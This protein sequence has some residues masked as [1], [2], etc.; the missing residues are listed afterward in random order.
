MHKK[1]TLK[2]GLRIITYPMKNTRALTL[3]ILV[4]TGSKYETKEISG[5]SHLLEHMAFKG[6]KKRPKTLDISRELDRI[7]GFYNAFTGKEYMGFWIKVDSSHFSL[8]GDILS[9]MIFNSLFEKKEIEKEKRVIFEE[10]NMRKDNPQSYVFEL[11]EKLLYGD[12]PAGWPIAGEKET[13]VKI[14]RKNIL[15]Y[16]KTQ[17]GA[18]NA[19]IVLAGNFEEKEGI[20]KVKK[21][22][23]GFKKV[24]PQ[25]KI[26][27]KEKQKKPEILLNFKETDQAHICLGVR[28]FDLFS[29][30]KYPLAVLSTILGGIM[31]SRLFIEVR[32]KRGLAYYIRSSSNHYTDNGYFLIHAGIDNKKIEE[33]IRVILRECKKL[34]MKKISQKELIKAKENIKGRISLDLETSDSWAGFLGGQEILERKIKT[35]EQKISQIEKVTSSDILK[36][37]K[38]IFLPEKLNLALI[39]PFKDKSKFQR[40]LKL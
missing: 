29:A 34:K 12:Q 25:E 17:F 18:E 1:T 32:E 22:F 24:S 19:V 9:D 21:S 5:I 20:T 2:N 39:G 40:L 28:A 13:V 3:L 33:A 38:E 35:P 30:K 6:T 7:G 37:A 15:D 23:K 10:I 16:F 11:F 36:V 14:S 26:K 31:S 8:G 27:T 4:A